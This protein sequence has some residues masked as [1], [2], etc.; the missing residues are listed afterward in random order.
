MIIC[1]G[2]G[3][4]HGYEVVNKAIALGMEILLRVPH[5][6]FVLKGEDTVNFKVKCLLV[7]CCLPICL[8][9]CLFLSACLHACLHVVAIVLARAA[10]VVVVVDDATAANAHANVDADDAYSDAGES[11]RCF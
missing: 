2:V 6:S 1:D 5:L 4:H 3:N 10:S 11:A 7:C 9:A 8:P